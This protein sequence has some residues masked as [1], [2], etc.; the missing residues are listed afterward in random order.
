MTLIDFNQG[1]FLN[2]ADNTTNAQ[3]EGEGE[4]QEIVASHDGEIVEDDDD[5]D[6]N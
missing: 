2:I 4:E 6:E 1:N 5:T 3:N